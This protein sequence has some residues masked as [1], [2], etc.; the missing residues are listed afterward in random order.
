M[1]D[2]TERSNRSLPSVLS[3]SESVTVTSFNQ[4]C[5][6][7][8][9]KIEKVLNEAG[10]IQSLEVGSFDNL[11]VPRV[12]SKDDDM[13]DLGELLEVIVEADNTRSTKS[14]TRKNYPNEIDFEEV[15]G[16]AMK[17]ADYMEHNTAEL[18]TVLTQYETHEV[19]RDE[20][21]RTLD[22]LRNLHENEPYFRRRI[23][24]IGSFLPINQPLYA[25]AC[26]SIVPSLMANQVFVR[27]P[28]AA[29]KV[30][31]EI[32]N[33]LNLQTHC[34][35]IK[36]S[37]QN[38]AD[39]IETC[40]DGEVEV[41]IFT[42]KMENAYRVRKSFSE[43]VLFIVNGAG[44]NP[45]VVAEDAD[46]DS[47]ISSAL[48]V[49]LYN[50]GQDCANPSAILVH[51]EVAQSFLEKLRVALKEV[52]VGGYQDPAVRVGPISNPKDLGRIVGILNKN[53]AYVDPE[54]PGI[55]HA[56]TGLVEPTIINRPLS[57]GGNYSEQ[58]A[59]IFFLH[60]Y[61][62]DEAL[63]AYFENDE[64]S[65]NAMYVSLFGSS[66]YVDGLTNL[67]FS[68][69][70][71]LHDKRQIIR[72][73]DLHAKGVE[74][75]TQ[76]Y[77]GYGRRASCLIVNGRFMPQPTLPQRD[78]FEQLVQPTLSERKEQTVQSKKG[79]SK[80]ARVAAER[81]LIIKARTEHKKQREVS[82]LRDRNV[83]YISQIKNKS[84]LER[85]R[86]FR[87]ILATNDLES[88]E[89]MEHAYRLNRTGQKDFFKDIYNLVIGQSAGPRISTLISEI[90]RDQLLMLLD[91]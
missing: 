25:L 16:R 6:E 13:I 8:K 10:L 88:D 58:L 19:A 21:E 17:M 20:I 61:E 62:S 76:P 30:F 18:I 40:K 85:I 38:R 55:T 83:D 86:E 1:K 60:E 48:R 31:S 67:R 75:G 65:Q 24:G 14:N 35:N 69:G 68:D 78:I 53:R 22:L 54:T 82:P 63:S 11:Q 28:V 4:L 9:L 74:R 81:T 89:I 56:K 91:V 43:D 26:F 50:Q 64:Y 87:E 66:T 57:E 23:G 12:I 77:G 90:S 41:I 79:V 73:N 59:P 37:D 36:L 47:A 84:R 51:S 80:E 3:D 29:R 15:N 70:R 52:I 71:R 42:G 72:N 7:S 33:T 45:I 46:L 39:F 49:Q 2:I 27:P 34:P 32:T 44:H 5:H